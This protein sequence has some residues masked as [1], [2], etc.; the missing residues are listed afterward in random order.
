MESEEQQIT[1]K[2]KIKS[3]ETQIIN[4][5]ENKAVV[6]REAKAIIYLNFEVIKSLLKK[7]VDEVEN[8]SGEYPEVSKADRNEI[9]II[10]K[11]YIDTAKDLKKIELPE[12]T[13]ENAQTLIERP[14]I[15]NEVEK[16]AKK[17]ILKYYSKKLM[18]G[19]KISKKKLQIEFNKIVNK[20]PYYNGKTPTINEADIEKFNSY[21]KEA[22]FYEK[23]EIKQDSK[24]ITKAI[25]LF[26]LDFIINNIK[27]P[28]PLFGQLFQ[29]CNEFIN[30]EVARVA[31][32]FQIANK[33]LFEKTPEN[34]TIEPQK[35]GE[36]SKDF[37]KRK[38][39]AML[40]KWIK[41]FDIN[42]ANDDQE[43][44]EKWK[45]ALATMKT[46]E[47]RDEDSALYM[48]A[49]HMYEYAGNIF[50]N[51]LLV[52]IAYISYKCK[53]KTADLQATV[54]VVCQLKYEQMVFTIAFGSEM[55]E[56]LITYRAN[57]LM[58]FLE[59]LKKGPQ[60]V[61]LPKEMTE[62]DKA[63]VLKNFEETDLKK[64]LNN[65]NSNAPIDIKEDVLKNI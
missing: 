56:E 43:F 59:N 19:V 12:I 18:E 41:V 52:Q 35:E 42:K 48:Y 63:K 29:N 46:R 11:A 51:Y 32:E 14:L 24:I 20:I 5:S 45:E 7:I 55:A 57:K 47:L 22:Y 54:N 60:V 33:P 8:Y 37:E 28:P 13:P 4:E 10:F 9:N 38:Y 64:I 50:F 21:Y 34:V 61:S 49:K 23:D 30:T 2:E 26:Y 25:Q 15:E 62:E 1:L 27:I 31:E 16:I 40:D 3:M 6:T 58:G 17:A 39:Q 65:T 44:V 36:S 53:E